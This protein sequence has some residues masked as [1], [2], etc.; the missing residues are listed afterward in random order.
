MRLAKT[1]DLSRE[2]EHKVF[3]E[4]IRACEMPIPRPPEVT[5]VSLPVVRRDRRKMYRK[6]PE[7]SIPGH[8][9]ICL[10]LN[11]PDTLKCGFEKR[12]LRELP[13]PNRKTLAQFTDFVRKYVSKLPMARDIPFDEWLDSIENINEQ[14]K[15]QLRESHELLRGGR[16]TRRQASHIDTFG[17]TESY[18]EFKHCRMINS[19]SDAF[20]AYSGRY[21]KAIEEIVYEL[22]EFIKHVPVPDRPARIQGLKR[23]GLRYYE[24][25]F[26]AYESHFT[27]ELMDI[28]ECALYRHCLKW[29]SEDAEFLCRTLTGVNRMRTRSGVSAKVLA[30]RM[31]GDMCTS[32]GNG[33]TNLMLVKFIAF[34]KQGTVEGF[35]EGDDGLFACNFEMSSDDYLE[36]GFTVKIVEVDDPCHAHFCGMIFSENGEII[37]DPFK[38]CQTFGWTS[39]L[40]GASKPIMYQLLRA[41]ALSSVFETPQ[42]PI[43]G[44]YARHALDVTSGVTARHVYDGY[45]A[46]VPDFVPPPFNPSADTRRLFALKFGIPETEQEAIEAQLMRGDLDGVAAVLI[47]NGDVQQ[48]ALNYLTLT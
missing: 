34:K 27:A 46:A 48:M 38:V 41:K 28:C 22:P 39:S 35:V 15:A 33:F 1:L 40:I 2:E 18:P 19:R 10:D 43:V 32:L 3:V 42:C 26:T 4:G 9:P 20:K 36:L 16:P 37:R 24:N 21:F 17:K 14:R 6:L 8:V 31:S 47:P 44:A 5:Q 45:H 25:D 7:I 11:D 29:C 13:T 30:R 23:A 12:L